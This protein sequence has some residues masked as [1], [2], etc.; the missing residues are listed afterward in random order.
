MSESSAVVARQTYEPCD[1]VDGG[2]CEMFGCVSITHCVSGSVS[3]PLPFRAPYVF[4]RLTFF[5][6]L[7]FFTLRFSCPT[8]GA[9]Q[10][11]DN[12]VE[13]LWKT[14]PQPVDKPVDKAQRVTPPRC[15]VDRVRGP[16]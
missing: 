5:D 11:V 8:L 16:R 3:G 2:R 7:T 15:E 6:H 4:G 13:M 12:P 9:P 10:A 14:Y 1:H